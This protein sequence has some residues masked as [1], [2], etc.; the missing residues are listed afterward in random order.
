MSAAA[1]L[2]E[3]DELVT[4]YGQLRVVQGVSFRL[5]R[6]EILAVIGANGVGKTTLLNALVGQLRILSLIHI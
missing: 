6:D 4:G 1:P 3:V 5:A 2:L